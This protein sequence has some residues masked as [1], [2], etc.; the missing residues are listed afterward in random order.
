VVPGYPPALEIVLTQALAKNANKRYPTANDLLKALDQSLSR[1]IRVSTDEEV[2]A[3]VKSLLSER[4]DKRQEAL[5]DALRIADDRSAGRAQIL[6]SSQNDVLQAQSSS[7]LRRSATSR[8][9]R[10]LRCPTSI[11]GVTQ[12]D[13]GAAADGSTDPSI[14]GGLFGSG[15]S[16][17]GRR[18]GGGA[19]ES[20][21][22]TG[23]SNRSLTPP[24]GAS[25]IMGDLSVAYEDTGPTAR[26][27]RRRMA[28]GAR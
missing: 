17:S 9:S 13:L 7:G 23:K 1:S 27:S 2:G 15:G 26:Q 22:G 18:A 10:F 5:R 4:R 12:P 24:P 20:Q 21:P 6:R 8:G 25:D 14:V 16:D 3:F 28:I 11:T 19:G